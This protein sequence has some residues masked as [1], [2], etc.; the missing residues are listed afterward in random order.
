MNITVIMTI[1][2]VMDAAAKGLA[3]FLI[4]AQV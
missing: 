4:Y 3:D 2:V 1:T